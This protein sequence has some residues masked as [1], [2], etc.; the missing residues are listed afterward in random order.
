[1]TSTKEL[2]KK[3]A[4][5]MKSPDL[6]EKE[7]RD[8]KSEI[9]ISRG[10]EKSLTAWETIQVA[11]HKDR[12][13]FKDYV[14][15]MFTDFIELHGDRRFSDDLAICGGFAHLGGESVMV[16]GHDKGKTIEE[17]GD[18]RFGCALPDGYRKAMRLMRLAERFGI[19]IITLID[20]QG[21]YPGLEGEE[22]GQAEAIARN[23]VEM[24]Q[25]SVPI[26]CTVVGEGG[27]GGAL[28][29]GVG[30]KVMM[31]SNSV[32]SVISAEGCAG[33]LWRDGSKAPVAAEALKPTA[34]SLL[35]L[36]VVDRVI[37]EPSGGAHSDYAGTFEALREA[38]LSE[39]RP[40]KKIAPAKL[41]KKRFEKFSAM[42]IYNE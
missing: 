35:K 4:A 19:P 37:Q 16:I 32:Y 33:I 11:R 23:L 26:I 22:R 27:S 6:F 8:L 42:G 28:G 20:T 38:V 10:G 17:K 2:E 29:I 40:L 13:T 1:M 31:L 25:I 21:A 12:P 41:T 18:R 36:K 30:D 15:G 14:T 24:A 39:L 9:A 34:E 5:L 3:L 7:I